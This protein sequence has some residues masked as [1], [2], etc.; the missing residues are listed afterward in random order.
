MSTKAMLFKNNVGFISL[1][2]IIIQD[3][4]IKNDD[5]IKIDFQQI[6]N[7]KKR[8]ILLLIGLSLIHSYFFFSIIILFFS[9]L[10]LVYLLYYKSNFMLHINEKSNRNKS[11]KIKNVHQKDIE[12]FMEKFIEVTKAIKI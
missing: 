10:Y 7:H 1:N 4:V 3:N 9:S 6:K 2:E 11:F 8:E 5:I 12:L